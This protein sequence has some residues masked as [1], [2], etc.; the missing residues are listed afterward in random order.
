MTTLA[1]LT[2]GVYTIALLYIT[3]YCVM[4]FNL[5]YYYKRGRRN[6]AEFIMEEEELPVQ[7]AVAAGDHDWGDTPVHH[8]GF[9]DD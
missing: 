7:V 9:A 8:H 6:T 5:L 1:F 3:V 4:Q 2:L